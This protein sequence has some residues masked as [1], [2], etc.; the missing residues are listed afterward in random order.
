MTGG[1]EYLVVSLNE[2]AEEHE[3]F[4]LRQMHL[5]NARGEDG[6]ELVHEADTGRDVL[7]TFKR[8]KQ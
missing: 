6:W 8:P 2:E 3:S 7:V 4:T 5:L 1:W